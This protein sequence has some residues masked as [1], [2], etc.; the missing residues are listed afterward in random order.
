MESTLLTTVQD[1]LGSVQSYGATRR[2]RRTVSMQDSRLR[3]S[4]SILNFHASRKTKPRS[5][6]Y[7]PVNLTRQPSGTYSIPESDVVLDEEEYDLLEESEEGVH[8]MLDDSPYEEVRACVINQDDSSLNANTL[9]MWTIALLFTILGSAVNLFF[10]LRFPSIAITALLAQL[11]SHP[12]G[13]AWERFMPDVT[14]NLLFARIRVND[15]SKPWNTKEH[16]C[17]F[18]ASN[19]SFAFAFATDV[20]T[21]Q[22]KF[23]GMQP[24]IIYQ[25]MFILSTQVI[26]YA[27]A[28]L[29]RQWLV[30]PSS[31]IWPS[32]LVNCA[33]F[34]VLHPDSTQSTGVDSPDEADS[35]TSVVPGPSRTKFFFILFAIA[36]LWAF[37]PSFIFP[38]LSYFSIVSWLAPK[39]RILNT[40]LGSKSGLGLLPITLD[41]AQM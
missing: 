2:G 26:G 25:V 37:I 16:C 20:L 1:P 21:E 27:F 19:V 18:I 6:S 10:S 8:L 33:L 4:T 39:S 28:G 23:Y 3:E 22:I 24:S 5:S 36:F 40:V 7:S 11:L 38:A 30:E 35:A 12:A 13:V 14:I 34:Q 29:S 15:K 17:V 9:R 41:W 32:V 31:M